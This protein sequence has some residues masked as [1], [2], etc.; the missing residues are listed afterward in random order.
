MLQAAI[1]HLDRWVRNGTPPA[2]APRLEITPG[3][4]PTINRDAHGY[5]LGGIRTP[6]VD[7]PIATLRGDG[8]SDKG[9]CLFSGTTVPFDPVTLA[10]PYPTHARY[11]A[12]FQRATESAVR[13]GFVLAP[14]AHNLE[15]A[16]AH[17]AVGNP[18]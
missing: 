6:L 5:A 11:V 4:P 12:E 8:N 1:F 18:G 13:A 7:V 17:S 3:P 15:A 16:A 2:R 10:A 9:Y 14:E